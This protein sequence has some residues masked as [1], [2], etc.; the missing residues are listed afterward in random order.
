MISIFHIH[1]LFALL[2][3]KPAIFLNETNSKKNARLDQELLYTL[4]PVKMK[5]Y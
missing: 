3:L 1:S 4:Y 5:R 2:S